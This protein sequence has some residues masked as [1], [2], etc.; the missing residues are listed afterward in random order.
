MT[1]NIKKIFI[2]VGEM[3]PTEP[4]FP[5]IRKQY[6]NNFKNKSYIL[7][8]LTK[9]NESR[10][11]IP[12]PELF[13]QEGS[14]PHGI[15]YKNDEGGIVIKKSMTNKLEEIFNDYT[16]K[17]YAIVNR[18]TAHQMSYFLSE[19]AFNKVKGNGR[20][21]IVI[22]IDQH[23]DYTSNPDNQIKFLSWGGNICN[24][25]GDYSANY[26]TD[27]TYI[28]AGLSGSGCIVKR[29]EAKTT[30]AGITIKEYQNIGDSTKVNFIIQS[31]FEGK[32]LNNID[33]YITLD[34]DVMQGSNTFYKSGI[35][36]KDEVMNIIQRLLDTIKTDGN[37]LVGFDVTGLPIR[38]SKQSDYDFST[39]DE[40]FEQTIS[41][42]DEIEGLLLNF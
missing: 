20:K 42:T 3:E 21:K 23:Y 29:Y 9:K 30:N 8:E 6:N 16:N 41:V 32:T 37:N 27:V 34:T 33:Y 28:V 24:L 18:N 38:T 14:S 17:L 35:Y 4:T 39:Y 11:I 36:S 2:D 26:G 7:H 25:T 15:S 1:M 22:N 5:I 31:I 10:L 13:S 12:D 40:S 19:Y